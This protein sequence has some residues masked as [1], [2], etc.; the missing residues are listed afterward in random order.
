MKFN[1]N[2][3]LSHL[4]IQQC[5]VNQ[6]VEQDSA[7][8]SICEPFCSI[9]ARDAQLFRHVG[10]V[11]TILDPLLCQGFSPLQRSF[12][13]GLGTSSVK[14][15]TSHTFGKSLQ[16]KND[17][18]STRRSPEPIRS[19]PHDHSHKGNFDFTRNTLPALINC[20]FLELPHIFHA[21]FVRYSVA[22]LRLLH[23]SNA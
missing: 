17:A 8:C 14:L 12:L 3:G 22:N 6:E 19:H 4:A 7:C 18:E 9:R 11:R 16:L 1:T 5:V 23:A 2:G 20:L 21:A 10:D 15:A 13:R